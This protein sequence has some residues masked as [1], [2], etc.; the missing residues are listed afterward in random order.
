MISLDYL[1]L[2]RDMLKLRSGITGP[3]MLKYRLEDEMIAEYV[4]QAAC[5]YRTAAFFVPAPA[6]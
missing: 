1:D 2:S 5:P 6:A 4:A 3:A